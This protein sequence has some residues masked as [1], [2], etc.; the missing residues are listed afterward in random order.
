MDI[1]NRLKTKKQFS[2][3]VAT[4]TKAELEAVINAAA[5][6]YY[7]TDK[8]LLTDADYDLLVESLKIRWPKSATLQKIGAP[9]KGKK[10][11]LPYHMGSMDKIKSDEKVL[12]KWIN[13][14]SGP[15]LISD[16]LDGISCLIVIDGTSVNMY[17]RG[18]G[19]IGQSI[20][21]LIEYIDFGTDVYSF[22]DEYFAI[23]GELVM[24]KKT[25]AKYQ[26]TYENS[27]NMIAGVVNSKPDKIN[28][29]ILADI[30]FVAYEMI[31]PA[32]IPNEQ[33]NT[34]TEYNFN[35]V[36]HRLVT[37]I[38]IDILNHILIDRKKKS[39]YQIDGII[40]TDNKKHRRNN[41]GNPTYS[42]AFKGISE[43]AD[44][45]VIEVLWNPS[46]DGVIVPKIHFES[47]KLSGATLDHTAGF[48]AKFIL[49]N[50]IGPGAI[51]T[52][53]RSGDTIPHVVKVVKPAKVVKLPVQY[54]FVWN[55]TRTNIV[56]QNPEDNN[57]VIVKRLTKFAKDTGIDNISEATMEKIVSEGYDTI[58]DF[59]NLTVEDLNEIKGFGATLS[60]K[61]Y[62][63]IQNAMNNINVHTLMVASN[64]FGHGMGE[65]KLAKIL[66]VYP[67]I[68]TKYQKSKYDMW[69]NNIINIEGF[70][71]ITT[72]AFVDNLPQFI[73]FYK[74]FTKYVNVNP[75]ISTKSRSDPNGV[76]A[77]QHVV[78]TGFRSDDIKNF[79]ELS[80]GKISSSVS[81]NTTLLVYADGKEDSSSYT[82][83][84]NLGIKMMSRSQFEKK[85]KITN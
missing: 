5:D 35:V 33:M 68:V 18:N 34:L 27:R 3:F 32:L 64:I 29:E 53:V 57:D 7:N 54:D 42:F 76:F 21:H 80:G 12:A 22:T 19:E 49:D 78:F 74:K 38:S 50:K 69:Y 6:A 84:L 85:Y 63:N 62:N 10:V 66:E 51:I 4:G 70:D 25:F 81:K 59:I 48:N 14:N 79:I 30:K 37:D 83:A 75:Y 36:Y 58:I 82:K 28:P 40:C 13:S 45:R 73:E 55:K 23:R 52:M 46:K 72:K 65:R 26:K 43:M 16:K 9:I 47:A 17:T 77:G 44:V 15:Y 67:D 60:K 11:T 39:P 71:V 8:P 31:K 24:T 20:D 2:E 41:T 1:V 61:I 56:L